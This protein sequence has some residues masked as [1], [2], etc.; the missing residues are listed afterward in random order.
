[1][2]PQPLPSPLEGEGG[3][4]GDEK[5]WSKWEFQS[6]ERHRQEGI[7]DGPIRN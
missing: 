6:A 3:V 2:T 7:N 1:M 5:G 4:G